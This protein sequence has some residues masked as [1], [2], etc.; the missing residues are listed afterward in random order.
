MSYV[1]PVLILAIADLHHLRC[2][3]L[4]TVRL[5]G[6]PKQIRYNLHCWIL[7]AYVDSRVFGYVSFDESPKSLVENPSS[8]WHL[9]SYACSNISQLR[10]RTC[11]RVKRAR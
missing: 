2:C 11:R 4:D 5:G 1:R 8:D 6:L 3:L 9:F 7:L 10:T